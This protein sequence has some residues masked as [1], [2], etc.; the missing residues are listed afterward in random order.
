MIHQKQQ[1]VCLSSQS[2]FT[3]IESLVAVIVVGILLAAIAPVIVLSVATRVQ[4]RRVELATDAAKI[5]INGV[6]SGQ[7]LPPP[8]VGTI[9][10]LGTYAAPTVGSLSCNTAND[11]CS[12][13][14]T[15][16]YC[17]DGDGS[18]CTISSTRDFVIQAFRY[19][20]S[21]TNA[22]D[23]YQLGIRVYRAD[24]FTNDG[25]NLKTAPS[26]QPTF[27]RGAGD[28]KA[29]LLETTTEISNRVTTF[30]DFCDRLKPPSGNSNSQSQC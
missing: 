14:A 21:S 27:T 17:V 11:Y 6:R 30:G 12:V 8:I 18:G 2:G 22:Q 5:Y 24:G 7:I 20:K 13:P 1:Q 10:N 29:P 16:L 9:D 19:N 23:G 28:R 15:N 25:G 3:I 4:A 26:K